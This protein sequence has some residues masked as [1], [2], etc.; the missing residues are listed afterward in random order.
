MILLH[1]RFGSQR[2]GAGAQKFAHRN[3]A[4]V[5]PRIARPPEI[6]HGRLDHN[7]LAIHP[8]GDVVF[9]GDEK[10]GSFWLSLQIK[11]EAEIMFP[12]RRVSQSIVIV[13]PDPLGSGLVS[14]RSNGMSRVI[15]LAFQS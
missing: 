9:R 7:L 1:N 15:H 10:R 3:D 2:I 11:I 6:S 13:R 5:S 8:G 14:P 4:E 12:R